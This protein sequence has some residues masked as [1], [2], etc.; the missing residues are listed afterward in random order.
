M[1]LCL[2]FCTLLSQ[3][4]SELNERELI[5]IQNIQKVNLISILFV[6]A[7][8]RDVVEICLFISQSGFKCN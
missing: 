8:G 2:S 6:M 1:D 3:A 5:Q 4:H 7:P